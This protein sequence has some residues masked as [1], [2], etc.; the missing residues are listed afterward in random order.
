MSSCLCKSRGGC[1]FSIAHRSCGRWAS[2]AVHF[3]ALVTC[4]C[5]SRHVHTFTELRRRSPPKLIRKSDAGIRGGA[6]SY[7]FLS[8]LR[9][10]VFCGLPRIA[11]PEQ[12]IHT[13]IHAPTEK[14]PNGRTNA[15]RNSLGGTA[16]HLVS[17][18]KFVGSHPVA[19]G[20]A[21]T[22]SNSPRACRC[23][24]R[25]AADYC[26]LRKGFQFGQDGGEIFRNRRMNMHC[27]LYYC[28]RRL[29]IH[30][31]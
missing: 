25:S 3:L 26:L 1:R 27:A 28:I 2:D 11:D 16:V 21:P 24:G 9:R 8:R 18:P 5:S 17:G 13:S 4:S 10:E 20:L 19:S 31:V 15:A 7:H 30:D 29:R 12:D 22:H 6:N 14:R 23:H